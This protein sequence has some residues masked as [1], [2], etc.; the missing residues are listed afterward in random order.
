MKAFHNDQ[1]IKD[2]YLKRVAAHE[3]ADEIVQAYGYWTGGKG[4]AIGCTLHGSYHEDYETELGIPRVI[5]RL[6]DGIFEGLP[7]DLAK[8]WP[9]RFL[10]CIKPGADLSLVW[11]KFAVWMLTDEEFGVIK[12]A[13]TNAQRESIQA[14][15]DMY[16]F[17]IEGA[18]ID[19][20]DWRQARASAAAAAAY[21]AAAYA[22]AAYAAA[23]AASASAAAAA[24]AAA[25]SA[26]A[27]A[28]AYAAARKKVRVAQSE[29]LIELL[30]EAG[31]SSPESK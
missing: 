12:F 6:E 21:A 3:V 16:L 1:A 26:A 17:K 29:K 27:A 13:R 28:D 15:S 22:D 2:K 19:S 9:R 8:T 20:A 25:A 5:A 10:E 30:T 24:A 4:C 11:P 18:E 14:I 31:N 23:A 7:N